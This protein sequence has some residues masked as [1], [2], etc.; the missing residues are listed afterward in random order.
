MESKRYN[1]LELNINTNMEQSSMLVSPFI[2]FILKGLIEGTWLTTF[3]LTEK[4]SNITPVKLK[5]NTYTCNNLKTITPFFIFDFR[6]SIIIDD[7]IQDFII[8]IDSDTFI[9]NAIKLNYE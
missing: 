8:E 7:I 6:D 9:I 1:I 2:E 3:N 5:C 4:W